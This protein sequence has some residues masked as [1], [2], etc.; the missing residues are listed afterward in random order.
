LKPDFAP[1]IWGNAVILSSGTFKRQIASAICIGIMAL[2]IGD[3]RAEEPV[4][5]PKEILSVL[6]YNVHGL[7][8]LIAKDDPR[9]RMPSIGWLSRRYDIILYQE[10]FEYHAE[11]AEQLDQ[12]AE[13]I[14]NRA[15]VGD[16]RR[17]IAKIVSW[18]FT[19]LVPNFSPPYGSGVSTFV[20]DD[21]NVSESNADHY[22]DCHGWFGANGDCWAAKGYL[23]IRIETPSGATIDV[24]NTHLESG[25]S[26]ESTVVRGKQLQSLAEAIER[27]S[28]GGAVIVAG[29]CNLAYIRPGDRKVFKKF[30]KRLGMSDSGA[31]PETPFWRER[32]FILYRSGSE[33]PR[34]GADCI[35][36]ALRQPP[37]VN[38]VVDLL[39]G[40]TPIANVFDDL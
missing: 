40:E 12:H 38:R 16:A 31:G 37:T 25:P 21:L 22:D 10:D 27:T 33:T 6:S 3:A 36:E 19:L 1:A 24:Y 17:V 28:R 4:P 11:L 32:D 7:F 30:R 2:P 13:F 8:A 26:D 5:P 29:D 9:D 34:N 23:R 15:R 20:S 35:L 18:P 39:D 14:G